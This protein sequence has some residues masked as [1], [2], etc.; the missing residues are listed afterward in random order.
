MRLNRLDVQVKLALVVDRTAGEELAVADGRLEGRRGPQL[1]GLGGLHVVVAI[2]EDRL[3]AGRCTA[4]LGEDDRVARRG[5][6]LG[7]EADAR[8]LGGEPL[9]GAARVGVVFGAGA[10]ARDAQEGEELVADAGAV[11]SQKGVEV[12][13]D[14]G[15]HGGQS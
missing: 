8:A 2:D 11:R 9:G 13:R 6:H 10:D 14:G 3:R 5:E 12:A 15:W 1:E 4:V 7:G